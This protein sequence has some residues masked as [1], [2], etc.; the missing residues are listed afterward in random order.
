[1]QAAR[2]NAGY[3]Y[4]LTDDLEEFEMQINYF[5]RSAVAAI[6]DWSARGDWVAV[7]KGRGIFLLV[8]EQG[9]NAAE[10]VGNHAYAAM[11]QRQ[12]DAFSRALSDQ[13]PPME[14]EKSDLL[15]P[16]PIDD[17]EAAARAMPTHELIVR[18][19]VSCV[20][21]GMSLYEAMNSLRR[22]RTV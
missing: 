21:G 22:T 6:R 12:R 9:I 15:P 19:Y 11:M 10:K 17:P 5:R 16:P 2:T 8:C 14:E 13:A 7:E 1:L 18:Y 3:K 20:A 4:S